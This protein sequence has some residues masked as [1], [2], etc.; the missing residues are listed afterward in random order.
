M[1]GIHQNIF[2][3]S[4]LQFAML[5]LLDLDI[6]TRQVP[7]CL[8]WETERKVLACPVPINTLAIGQFNTPN[9]CRLFC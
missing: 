9:G 1:N 8:L 3:S 4:S 5:M 7:H 2:A 6:T